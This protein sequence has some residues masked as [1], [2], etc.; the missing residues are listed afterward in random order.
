MKQSM[1]ESIKQ[2]FKKLNETNVSKKYVI[3]VLGISMLMVCSYFSYAMFTVSKEKQ[4]A[5]KIVT[6]NLTYKLTVNG[7]ETTSISV[8]AKTSGELTVVL[9]NPNSRKV[10]FNFYYIES[11]AIKENISI[12]YVDGSTEPPAA[13]GTTYAAGQSVT[14]KIKV[15]NTSSGIIKIPFGVKAGLDY[16]DL[17]LPTNLGSGQTAKTFSKFTKAKTTIADY[18]LADSSNNPNTSDADQTFIT[19]SSPNNYIWYS[20]KMWRGVSVDT[21]DRSVK[22]VTD[23][24]ISVISYGNYTVGTFENSYI[25][26]WLNDES[27]DGFLGNLRDYSSFIKTSSEWNATETSSPGKPDNGTI[28][29]RAVGLLNPYEYTQSYAGVEESQGYLQILNSWWLL[30]PQSSGIINIVDQGGLASVES[31][32]SIGVRPAINFQAEIQIA[33][34][35]GTESNPY[36]LEGDT[37]ESGGLST[38]YSGEYVSF[39]TGDNSLYRIVSH[40]IDGTTKIVSVNPIADDSS[41]FHTETYGSY[42][43]QTDI[44]LGFF[45]NNDFLNQYLESYQSGMLYEDATW[46]LG[47]VLD[48]E[49]YMRAK[50]LDDEGNDLAADTAVAKVGLLRYGELFATTGE[51]KTNDDINRLDSYGLA[52]ITPYNSGMIHN[53][54]QY[55][56]GGTS[57]ST[58]PY[59]F[60]PAMFI[61]EEIYIV[62]GSGTKTD[63]FIIDS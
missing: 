60:R 20:G 5:I 23:D 22:A 3:I 16:N 41:T 32:S 53:I 28:V 48:G 18:L 58:Y 52:T 50:Y 27:V 11:T 54:K 21:S 8:P 45:L 15:T 12:G 17:E 57:E 1:K 40:E 56:I 59:N 10:R 43:Y 51:F 63:P 34:G 39:G 13:T 6:G 36:R 29:T 33:Y 14:Y 61:K 25:D 26:K 24:N 9:T 31:T 19:G 38:R 7:A 37:P 49:S 4:N 35:D 46:Y 47:T 42:I 62:G 44:E 55:D 2:F 30:S